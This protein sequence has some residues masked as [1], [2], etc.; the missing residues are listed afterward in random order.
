VSF[1][2]TLSSEI[3]TLKIKTLLCFVECVVFRC[4]QSLV[5]FMFCKKERKMARR[6]DHDR[7]TIRAMALD[8]AERI[9]AT[10]GSAGFSARKVAK[11][12]GYTVGTLYL[13]FENLDDI[14]MQVNG[15]TLDA[16]RLKLE[17][18]IA[19]ETQKNPRAIILAQGRA[20]IAYAE[21]EEPRWSML[22]ISVA[23]RDGN[24]P[25]WYQEKMDALFRPLENSLQ[26][27][28]MDADNSA[29]MARGLWSSCHGICYLHVFKIVGLMNTNAEVMMS[30]ALDYALRGAVLAKLENNSIVSALISRLVP[31][32]SPLHKLE[33][34]Q[35]EK[36]G[37]DSGLCVQGG[38][39][40]GQM[41]PR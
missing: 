15:R 1:S 37:E 35:T 34:A 18:A 39:G 19:R 5:S 36:A 17:E 22:F 11:A 28:G 27:L 21:A 32:M 31:W 38:G 26:Q 6:N 20:Y 7:V 24:V 8:A 30:L 10:E 41:I 3:Q 2:K 4:A 14:V 29:V 33:D 13:V 40:G 16:L 23:K 25:H 12:I 9:I